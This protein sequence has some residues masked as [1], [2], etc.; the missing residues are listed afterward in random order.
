MD[1]KTSQEGRVGMKKTNLAALIA[2]GILGSSIAAHAQAI[3]PDPNLAPTTSAEEERIPTTSP[4]SPQLALAVDPNVG[5]S[6]SAEEARIPPTSP[7]S[8]QL[9][10]A[11]NP[12][13]GQPSSTESAPMQAGRI[14]GTSVATQ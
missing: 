4:S 8:P 14:S 12:D 7:N 9:A 2:A 3:A 6:T 11:P 10:V 1:A 13:F 5:P